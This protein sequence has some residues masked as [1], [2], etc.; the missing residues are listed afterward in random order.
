[1]LC[2]KDPMLEK[3][4]IAATLNELQDIFELNS[5]DYDSWSISHELFMLLKD[6]Q[7]LY[8]RTKLQHE[9]THLWLEFPN[10]VIFGYT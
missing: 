2:L 9:L 5:I 10:T 3:A 6:I 4:Y 8:H 7:Y 1:M